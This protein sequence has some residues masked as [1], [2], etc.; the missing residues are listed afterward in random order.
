VSTTWLEAPPAP[1]RPARPQWERPSGHFIA[2]LASLITIAV[3]LLVLQR[4]DDDH[5]KAAV[6]A[7]T[8]TTLPATTAEWGTVDGSTYRITVTPS[9]A[10]SDEPSPN[11]CLGA[12]AAGH[13]NLRFTLRIENLSPD[14]AAP[15][16]QVALGTNVSRAGRVDPAITTLDGASTSIEVGPVAAGTSCSL[17]RAI[18]AGSG[19]ALTPGGFTEYSGVAG[20]LP[21]PVPNDLTLIVRYFA[22]DAAQVARGTGFSA[23]DLLVPFPD[24]AA[25]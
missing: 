22:A 14:K 21:S 1:D 8:T 19:S 9:S 15:V 24:V 25:T 3:C 6:A 12:P 23:V 11:G 18:A 13:T 10:A 7:S 2:A 5:D 4:L 16:P 17:A 20:G